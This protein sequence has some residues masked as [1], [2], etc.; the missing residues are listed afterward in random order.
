MLPH[1]V[2][3]CDNLSMW[4]EMANEMNRGT[5]FVLIRSRLIKFYK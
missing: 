2:P 1:E 5:P 4:N 3:V